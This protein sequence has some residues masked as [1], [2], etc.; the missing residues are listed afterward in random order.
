MTL[1]GVPLRYL[2]KIVDAPDRI[3]DSQLF[4]VKALVPLDTLAIAALLASGSLATYALQVAL[5][6]GLAPERVTADLAKTFPVAAWRVRGV[7][8]AAP[9]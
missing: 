7:G 3:S 8:E 1:G 6:A 2:G 9:I 4:G 5:P